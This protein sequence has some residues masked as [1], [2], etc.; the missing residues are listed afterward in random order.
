MSNAGFSITLPSPVIIVMEEARSSPL[1]ADVRPAARWK[2]LVGFI[3]LSL[4]LMFLASIVFVLMIAAIE[5]TG[6][7]TADVFDPVPEG[8]NRLYGEVVYALGVS[9]CLGLLA[10]AVL[11]SA[12]VVYGVPATAFLWPGRPFG[13]RQL[14][15][16]FA[17]MAVVGSASFLINPTGPAPIL[18]PAYTIESRLFYIAAAALGLFVA[19]AAEE[20]VFR[21]VLLRITGGLTGSLIILYAYPTPSCFPPFTWIPIR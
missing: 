11:L 15:L 1:I 19:A 9:A 14:W 8:P 21:G 20:V 17:A 16:G 2:R 13:R 6:V 7:V 5:A 12:K 10:G 3:A 18:N 4:V